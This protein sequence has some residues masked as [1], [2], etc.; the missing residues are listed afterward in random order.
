MKFNRYFITTGDKCRT[1]C[2]KLNVFPNQAPPKKKPNEEM[3]LIRASRQF[4]NVEEMRNTLEIEIRGARNYEP[5]PEPEP[6]VFDPDKA[7][8]TNGK[9]GKHG[10]NGKGGSRKGKHGN[11]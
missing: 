5:L 6:Y 7:N 3:F 11:K 4:L 9:N 8:G 1:G 2:T 10:K